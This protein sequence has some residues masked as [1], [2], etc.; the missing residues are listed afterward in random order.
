MPVFYRTGI[1]YIIQ[2][3]KINFA[4][5]INCVYSIISTPQLSTPLITSSRLREIIYKF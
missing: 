3:F 4:D 1:C 2:L 5:I